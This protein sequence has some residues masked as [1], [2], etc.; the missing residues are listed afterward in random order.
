MDEQKLDKAPEQ[1]GG[2]GETAPARPEHHSPLEPVYENIQVPLVAVDIF[3]GL[4]V[5]ALIAVVVVGVL[6]GNGLL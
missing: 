1:P 5:L 4:C 3:I 6:K 2:E